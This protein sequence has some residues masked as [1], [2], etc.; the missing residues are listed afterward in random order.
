MTNPLFSLPLCSARLQHAPTSASLSVLSTVCS[1]EMETLGL[2]SLQRND[3]ACKAVPSTL[4]YHPDHG[5][6]GRGSAGDLQCTMPS[7]SMVGD[8][9]F[10]EISITNH[11]ASPAVVFVHPTSQPMTQVSETQLGSP[12]SLPYH[13]FPSQPY[14]STSSCSSSLP[15]SSSSS[16]SSSNLRPPGPPVYP[17]HVVD[18]GGGTLVSIPPMVND[19]DPITQHFQTPTPAQHHHL[20][21]PQPVMHGNPLSLPPAL[22]PFSSVLPPQAPTRPPTDPSSLSPHHCRI[23]HPVPLAPKPEPVSPGSLMTPSCFFSANNSPSPVP[24]WLAG[25]LVQWVAVVQRK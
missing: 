25:S 15:S 1:N 20:V 19:G 10:V 5:V 16:S 13:P 4:K 21:H 8:L 23:V 3:E 14:T 18:G 11:P 22:V 7:H 24:W 17:S 12:A 6:R 2:S 9:Q